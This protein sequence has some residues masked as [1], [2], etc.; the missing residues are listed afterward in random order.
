[1][2]DLCLVN[3]ATVTLH[4]TVPN[5]Y[6]LLELLP[7]ED[8][9]F[10]CLDLKDAFFSI[11]LASESQKRFAFQWENP[12]T[13]VTTQYTWTWLPQGFKNSP[14]IFGEALAC[15]LQEFPA[16]DLGCGECSLG[17]E[18]KQIICNLPGPETRRQV[19]EFLG[20]VGFCRLWIPNF[21]VLA[22]P[23]YGVTKW[24]DR[25]P[26]EW[27]SQQRQNFQD[28]KEKLMS[29]LAL[30]LPDLTKPLTLKRKNGSW[31][32][33]TNMGQIIKEGWIWLP[34]GK[35]VV[36]QLLGA[37]VVQ[38]IRDTIHLVQESLE[39]SL[40]RY[41]YISHL[42]ALTK[43]VVQQCITCWQQNMRQGPT[44]PPGIQAYGA[45]PFEDLQVDFTEMPKC[46][47]HKYGAHILWVAFSTRTE[48]AH[49]VTHLIPRFGLPSSI[50]SDNR[51]ASVA[52]LVQ[53]T[54]MA[55]G[56]TWK[57]HAGLLT[58]EFRKGGMDEPDY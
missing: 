14:T 1:M 11:R 21:A 30:G 54:T 8:S 39:K 58:T 37:V 25:E 34:G 23:L 26:F 31:S 56:I 41:F 47:G 42:S 49:E 22:K 27:G 15:D 28:L 3:P 32:S 46:G 19:R 57:R 29:A 7:V 50:S 17:A 44:I 4:P 52:N 24:G 48:K 9:W 12:E 6:L 51:P 45:A 33:N 18:R 53:K 20:A 38:A 2:R 13:G 10:T 43:T 55:L 40:G 35:V 16:E 36:P 5:P